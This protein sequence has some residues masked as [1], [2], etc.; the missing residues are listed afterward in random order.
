M[1]EVQVVNGELGAKLDRY[2]SRI[3]PFGFSGALL[4]AKNGKVLLTKGYGM[5][6]REKGVPNTAETVFCT[7][8]ITKQ[9][10]AAAV[11][12]LWMKGKVDTEDRVG[13][14]LPD[15][16]DDKSLVTVHN[17]LT[18]TAGLGDSVGDD[19]EVLSRDV[20]VRR[21]LNEPLLSK[22]GTIY[23]YSNA[24]FGLLAAI[25][26]I[27]S[28]ESYEEFLHENLFVPAGMAF[29]G[30]RLPDWS[31]KVVADWYVGEVNNGNSLGKP[32]PHWNL[33]GNGGILST[34]GDMF[35]WHVALKDDS[36]LSPEAKEKLFTPFLND[37]AYGW[38][39]S[40]S[41]YGKLIGHDGGNDLGATADFRWFVDHD[42]ATIIFSNRAYFHGFKAILL[43]DK[44]AGLVFGR[45]VSV[46]PEVDDTFSVDVSRFL[47]SYRLTSGDLFRIS[48]SEG[49][50]V[51][52]AI[53]QNAIGMLFPAEGERF[54]D[55]E[56]LNRLSVEI[57]EGVLKDDYSGFEDVLK[58]ID[59]LDRKRRFVEGVLRK[60]ELGAVKKVEAVGSL[61]FWRREGAVETVVQVVFEGGAVSLAFVWHEGRLWG[62]PGSPDKPLL[63]LKPV[64]ALRFGGYSLNLSRGAMVDFIVG[65]EGNVVALAVNGGAEAKKNCRLTL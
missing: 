17:L 5:A 50:L 62:I 14:Y 11:M 48:Y 54:L 6:V 63:T 44:V 18:H 52:E 26:E 24:G 65:S 10:T 42:V 2:M 31:G 28:G 41:E 57:C 21:V 13:V 36:I 46:P 51:L 29:T 3:T 4:V 47:G 27:V 32:F 45:D 49:M 15:V 59:T 64:S 37:Y 16:P 35:K 40:Q 33:V 9:F 20:F 55:A 19:Y 60:R 8:S 1:S 12:K 23:E 43:R 38:G 39:V 56:R 61:P 22:P 30:Y 7:G 53:G 25:V 58:D 34:T